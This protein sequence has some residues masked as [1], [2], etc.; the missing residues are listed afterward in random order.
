M[1]CGQALGFYLAA[2][3]QWHSSETYTG[4]SSSVMPWMMG[5]SELLVSWS[6]TNLE[7]MVS[8]LES[9]ATFQRNF[10]RLKDFIDRN[11]LKV[12][13]REIQSPAPGAEWPL[14]N[15]SD[16]AT[17]LPKKIW[18]PGQEVEH[19]STVCPYGSEVT[20]SWVASSWRG[21][22]QWRVGLWNCYLSPIRWEARFKVAAREIWMKW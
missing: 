16:C 12:Q 10:G 21:E 3:F 4:A 8:M 19:Q 11:Y 1:R 6:D 13:Q 15:I 18:S 20:E 5:W 14:C 22:D 17:A 9:R 2:T 7:G